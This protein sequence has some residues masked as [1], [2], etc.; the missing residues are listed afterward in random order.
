[1]EIVFVGTGSGKTNLER[2]HSSL[3]VRRRECNVLIDVGDGASKALLKSSV[4][5]N[6]VNSILISHFHADHFAGLPSL[7]T[8]M[9]LSRRTSTLKIFVPEALKDFLKEL[10]IH[11]Y[12]FPEK[13]PFELVICP[14]RAGENFSPCPD[15]NVFPVRNSHIV[16]KTETIKYPTAI[17][18]SFSFILQTDSLKLLYTS[19]LGGSEDLTLFGDFYDVVVAELTHVPSGEMVKFLKGGKYEKFFFTHIDEVLK[20]EFEK[21]IAAEFKGERKIIFADDG[22]R[23]EI[24]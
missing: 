7:L 11:S 23:F 5:F 9:Y 16:Q 19:D 8:Q 20:D 2:F 12:L 13:L 6:E 3:L 15:L 18:V 17:F 1:M 21:I 10:L 4:D 22:D 14:F 24:P